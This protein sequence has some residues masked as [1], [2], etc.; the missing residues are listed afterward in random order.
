M[1]GLLGHPLE[2]RQSNDV[3]AASYAQVA[4]AHQN[5]DGREPIRALAEPPADRI[6]QPLPNAFSTNEDYMLHITTLGLD[7]ARLLA[8]GT[9][10][11]S[12]RLGIN[13]AV[14]VVDAAGQLVVLHR[15]DGTQPAGPDLA[16]A[17]ARTAAGFRKPSKHFEDIAAAG[18]RPGLLGLPGVF[19]GLAVEGGVPV[20]LPEEDGRPLV[21]VG[22][23]G[24]S[25]G[26]SDEDAQVA[27]EAIRAFLAER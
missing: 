21:C 19:G 12:H 15:M 2:V 17:K 14:A 22:A 13:V 18:G 4:A 3:L 25:G 24:V 10:K 9:V 1:R 8:D 16:V 6:P 26:R 11:A 23:L 27:E 5:W 20:W 7:E